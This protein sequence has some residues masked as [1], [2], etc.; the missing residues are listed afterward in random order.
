L[1]PV[2]FLLKSVRSLWGDSLGNVLFWFFGLFFCRF[3]GVRNLLTTASSAK[4]RI[5]GHPFLSKTFARLSDAKRWAKKTETEVLDGIYFPQKRENKHT[6]AELIDR[7]LLEILPRKSRAMQLTQERQLLWW[8]KQLGPYLL[9]NITPALIIEQRGI[10]ERAVIQGGVTRSPSTCN[11]YV[12][13]LRHALTIAHR[14]WQWMYDNPARKV[15]KLKEPRGR[16]RCLNDDERDRLL[17]A[18]RVN[19]CPYIYDV[20][21]LGLSTGMRS[22]EIRSLRWRQV[23]NSRENQK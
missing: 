13:A 2:F 22:N 6:V 8:K 14:D 19:S 7:Y 4:V 18:C 3:G 21:L 16:I 10:L 5:K 9:S 20:V 15:V 11:R 23:D 17:E 12:A 1:A